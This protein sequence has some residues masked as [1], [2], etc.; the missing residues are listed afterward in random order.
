MGRDIGAVDLAA[1]KGGVDVLVLGEID[2]LDLL[3]A[4]LGEDALGSRDLPLAVAQPGLEPSLKL[5]ASG[6][7]GIEL[8]ASAGMTARPRQNAAAAA[9]PRNSLANP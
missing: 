5:P 6:L 4:V 7:V 3:E 1:G 8:S 2:Q 9:A